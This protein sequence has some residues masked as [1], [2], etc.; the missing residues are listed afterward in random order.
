MTT[1]TASQ[2]WTYETLAQCN[3]AQ[4]EN[5]LLTGSAPDPEQLNGWIYC[6]WNHELVG[7]LSGEKFKKGFYK[8]NGA[9]FGYNEICEQDSDGFRGNWKVRLSNGRP[10]QLG[11]FRSDL[12][13]EEPP[14]PLYK[15]YQHLGHFNY[16]LPDM[17]KSIYFFFT[18]YQSHT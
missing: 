6:G 5:I 15:P 17:Y 14:Q 18:C 2:P 12:V 10:T 1:T 16:D 8:K 11:Y 13:K 4:L 7:K 9:N 3:P